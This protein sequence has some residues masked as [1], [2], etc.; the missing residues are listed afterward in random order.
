MS[1]ATS[2]GALL[3][4][5]GVRE[6]PIS[7]SS[8]SFNS[9]SNGKVFE[10]KYAMGTLSIP[11]EGIPQIMDVHIVVPNPEKGSNT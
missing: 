1:N 4:I 6:V 7:F 9:K 8:F 2:A 11:A 3:C 10:V 5:L